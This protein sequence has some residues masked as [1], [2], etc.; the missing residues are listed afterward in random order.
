MTCV[1]D[2]LIRGIHKDE[3]TRR[4]IGNYAGP[5]ELVCLLKKAN[6]K[7]TGVRWQAEELSERQ[8]EENFE[9]VRDYDAG[10]IT[11]GHL[12][13]TADP[14]VLLICYLLQVEVSMSINGS[15]VRMLPAGP[16]RY[17]ISLR[18]VGG[19]MQ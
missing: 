12:T 18:A 13:S 6:C 19:H 11:N 10:G 14:F 4:A 1:W 8:L 7:T 15:R 16:P 9:W 3:V 17:T 5:R 2:A